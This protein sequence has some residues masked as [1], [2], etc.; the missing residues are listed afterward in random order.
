MCKIIQKS[1]SRSY[2][3]A[4]IIFVEHKCYKTISDGIPLGSFTTKFTKSLNS[5]PSYHLKEYNTFC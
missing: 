4:N 1:L 3:E 2:Y 5:C